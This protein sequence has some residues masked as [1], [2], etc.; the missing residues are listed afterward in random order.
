MSDTLITMDQRQRG[1]RPHKEGK[2][3]KTNYFESMYT[4]LVQARPNNARWPIQIVFGL[5]T[6][7][8][9]QCLLKLTH[10][11]YK[12]GYKMTEGVDINQ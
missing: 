5:K 12:E 2:F 8:I 6:T 4:N 7:L 9:Y 1:S 10:I 11:D 3:H